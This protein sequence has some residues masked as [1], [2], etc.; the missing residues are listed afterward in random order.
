[1]SDTVAISGCSRHLLT[2]EQV[3]VDDE[4]CLELRAQLDHRPIATA[5]DMFLRQ[6]LE[7]PDPVVAFHLDYDTQ[8]GFHG[9]WTTA[10]TTRQIHN[11]CTLAVDQ[12]TSAR[13]LILH[14]H[15][16]WAVVEEIE[17]DHA[18][19]SSRVCCLEILAQY[20]MF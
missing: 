20:P 19:N 12:L 4:I 5:Y 15:Q 3:R 7:V 1:V 8:P 13:Y 17:S 10:C 16:V 11:Q 14:H 18:D 2:G 9:R 6:M